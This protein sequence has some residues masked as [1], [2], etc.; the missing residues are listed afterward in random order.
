MNEVIINFEGVYDTIQE[1]ILILWSVRKTEKQYIS[2]KYYANT[3]F[4]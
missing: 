4:Y 1:P 2:G 3:L